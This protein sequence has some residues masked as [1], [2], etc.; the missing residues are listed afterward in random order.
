MRG[1]T[2]TRPVA[3]REESPIT[4]ERRQRFALTLHIGTGKTGTTSLQAFLRQNRPRLA[5]AGWLYPRSIG[6]HS[7]FGAWIRPDDELNKAFRAGRPGTRGF[8]TVEELYRKVPRRLLAEVRHTDLP[9][10][11]MSDEG[12]WQSSEGSMERLRQ[13]A[14]AHTSGV[15]LVCYLRRQDDHLVS[16]YQQRVKHGET[17]TLPQRMAEIDLAKTYDYHARL[18]SWQRLL[19]PTVIVVRRFERDALKGGSLYEDFLDAAGIP[20]RAADLDHGP[21]RNESLDAASV[22]FLRLV[23]LLRVED[24]AAAALLPTNRRLF[25]RL[26]E[27]SEGPVLTLQAH[28]LDEFMA[29][30][31]TGNRAVA[32]TFLGDPSEELFRQPRKTTNTTVKQRLDPGR[33]DQFLT[34][35]DLPEVSHAP[36]RCLAEREALAG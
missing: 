31:E 30:W 33:I 8:G 23:N 32:R 19:E 14:D 17:R 34:M 16:R 22:E 36:L 10:V 2:R 1:R 3:A 11:L 4:D 15:R 28:L 12:L 5:D 25:T 29:R 18:L 6:R 24:Q 35:L 13:F 27:L 9:R 20:L 26:A 21:R 7:T